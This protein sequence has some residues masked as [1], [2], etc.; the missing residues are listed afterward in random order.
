[1][2][3]VQY[4]VRSLFVR[5]ATTIATVL[6]IALVVFVLSSSQMLSEGIQRTMGRSGKADHAFVLRKGSDAELASNIETRLVGLIKSAPGVK[7]DASGQPMG[8]GEVVL[9]IALDLEGTDGQVANVLVRGVADNVLAFRPDVKIIEGRPAQP[10]TNEVIVGERIIGRFK[11]L[12]MGG[13]IELSKNRPVAVVGVFDS[14]GSSFESEIWADVDTVRQ[15]FGRE[16]YVS[17]VTVALESSEKFDAFSAA[18]QHDKQLG[19]EAMRENEYYEKQSEGTSIFISAL[20]TSIV[21]FFFM[22]AMIGA[23]ITMYAAVANRQR[24]IG[25][26]RALGFSRMAVLLSFLLEAVILALAGGVIG[27]AASLAMK[28]AT[29]SMMNFATW[30]EVTFSFEPTPRIIVS[31][32]IVGALMGLI[33]GFFPA[34]R[35]ART[36]PVLAMRE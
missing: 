3:P 33:G 10:G 29:F 14:G 26:L 31:A 25:T 22:G 16:G 8:I 17:S 15:A 20:G 32:V 24:E 34:L 11:G 9:V 28:L 27:A 6:G 18:V 5:K 36:S 1:M 12:R 21:V 23:T 19:L 4:N 30:S 2:I 13:T 35:A 7:K